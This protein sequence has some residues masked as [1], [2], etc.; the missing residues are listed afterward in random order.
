MYMRVYPTA[1]SAV[2]PTRASDAA[3]VLV[4]DEVVKL[5]EQMQLKLDVT[6]PMKVSMK[7]GLV[8]NLTADNCAVTSSTIKA[9]KDS[10]TCTL[11]ISTT[12]GKNFRPTVTT[13][14]FQL[15]R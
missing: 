4:S 14:V 13:R 5:K 9:L 2:S 15:S 6:S 11:T 10:G 3:T 8:P 1:F 7:S 12:G